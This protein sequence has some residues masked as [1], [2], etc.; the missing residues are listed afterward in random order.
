M[1]AFPVATGEAGFIPS[2]FLMLVGWAFMT[3]VA[4][5]L[6]EVNLWMKP[7]EHVI[8]MT[9]RFLGFWGKSVAWLLY[10]FICYASLVAYTSGT[11]ELC[12]AFLRQ[13]FPISD[14]WASVVFV[15]L[16]SFVV[17]LGNIVIGR[18]NT[19]LVVGLIVSY[20]L[21][22][23][24]SL[25]SID[26]H[27]WLRREW[28]GSFVAMP[29][30]LSIFS[31]HTILPS[32]TIYLKQDGKMLRRSIIYGTLSALAIYLI[33]QAVVLGALHWNNG[34]ET[35]LIEGKPATKFFGSG[36]GRPLLGL[37]AD[38][39]AFFAMVT[40]FLGIGMGLFD[41]LADG[42]KIPKV[43]WGAVLLGV[44]IIV[45]TLFFALTVKRVF[46]RALD[47]TGGIGDS[48]LNALFPALM[49]WI[50]RYK[51]KLESEYRIPG[52]KSLIFIAMCYAICVFLLEILG[53][54][55]VVKSLGGS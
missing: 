15:L 41:F 34:L 23:L 31:F 13:F 4:L 26:V 8:A 27:N 48:I 17:Y 14:V 49:L 18:V 20:L 43:R 30:L 52:G 40:S 39:F 51:M 5:Y 50:G 36:T 24:T 1:L 22:V 42:L 38:A 25:K 10:L 32:L 29:L 35:S 21:L 53:M 54:L 28:K 47:S 16:A 11:S 45:P 7:G 19:L 55:G 2:V 33:W 6:S 46:L 12:G 9:S 3:L 37:I 44:M